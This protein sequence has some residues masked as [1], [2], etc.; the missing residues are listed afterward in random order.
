[1][2]P[3]N[4]KSAAVKTVQRYLL[5]PESGIFDDKTRTAIK[6]FQSERNLEPTGVVDYKSFIELQSRYKTIGDSLKSGK[7][8]QGFI[9][10]LK[11][12]D[13]GDGIAILNSVLSQVLEKYS[14]YE[15]LPRGNYY[16]VYTVKAVSRLRQIFGLKVGN[17]VDA[18]FYARLLRERLT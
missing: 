7:I 15:I 10:P 1:M 9:F 18:E 3:I 13:N 5:L 14:Y 4:N 17:D 12:G 6:E 8:A 11:S 2:Y 16:N